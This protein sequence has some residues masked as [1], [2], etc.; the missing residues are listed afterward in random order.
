MRPEDSYR[1]RW[2]REWKPAWHGSIRPAE[3][4]FESKSLVRDN[5]Q[6]WA[7]QRTRRAGP[8]RGDSPDHRWRSKFRP[9]ESFPARVDSIALAPRLEHVSCGRTARV[10]GSLQ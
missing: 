7:W 5:Q 2:T 6:V 10:R 9:E 3:S 4:A 8:A 1:F